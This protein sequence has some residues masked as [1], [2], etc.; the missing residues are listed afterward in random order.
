MTLTPRQ[1]NRA[2]PS[3]SSCPDGEALASYIDG[4]VTTAERADIEAHLASCEDCYFVFSETVQEQEVRGGDAGKKSTVTPWLSRWYPQL[5]AGLAAAAAII[6]AVEVFG[7]PPRTQPGTTVRVALNELDA[8][9]GPYRK[10]EPRL[11]LTFTHREL[12]PALR[13][14]EPSG[15]V[16][17]AQ[18]EA[19]QRALR[20]AAQRVEAAARARGT[21]VEGQRALAAMY[22]ALGRAQPA[23]DVL[24]TEEQSNDAG[25]LSDV[26]A[27]YLARQAEGDV[28]HALDLL[29]RAVT[30]DPKRAEAWFNLGL[31]ARAAR[32]TARAQEA[33]K[34]YLVLDPSSEWANE[35]RWHLEKLQK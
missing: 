10:F 27:A 20:E 18:R 6:V 23:A 30:L 2:W 5:V 4:R 32:Q 1:E 13:S 8:V 11:T 3:G 31:A 29:E 22:F 21:G 7:P 19:S 16:S 15:D 35:A 28:Q 33:W 14:A 34:Q 26:A 24:E 17:L 25:V 9:A 12:E